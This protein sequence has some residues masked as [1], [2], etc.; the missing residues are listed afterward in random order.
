MLRAATRP[1]WVAT[2]QCSILTRVPVRKDG[3]AQTS[4]AAKKLGMVS[5]AS[6][7]LTTTAPSLSRG[8]PSRKR[9]L[10]NTP[11]PIITP[12]AGKTSPSSSSTPFTTSLPRNNRTWALPYHFTPSFCSNRAKAAP[13][14]FP[15]TLSNGTVSIAITDTSQPML[16]SDEAVS[17]PM[18]EPPTTTIFRPFLA[19]FVISAA[20][21][22]VRKVNMPFKVA[23]GTNSLRGEPP[24][25]TMTLSYFIISSVPAGVV[26]RISLLFASTFVTT[27]SWITSMLYCL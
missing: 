7:G 16:F 21:S 23:P 9:V 17:I 13:T 27:A 18:N 8:T 5:A 25:A 1:C 2:S 22:G 12:S 3:K 26:Y 14:F 15:S 24:D 10:G 20:S 6:S 19:N 4:P 11:A